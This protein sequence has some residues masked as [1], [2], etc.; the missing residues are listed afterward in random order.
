[1]VVTVAL[2]LGGLFVAFVVPDSET[3]LTAT[4]DMFI[5]SG[6]CCFC[7]GAVA[8]ILAAVV[9]ALALRRK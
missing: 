6:I 7:P 8:L 1:L 3:G 5:F 9:W 2:F 4:G